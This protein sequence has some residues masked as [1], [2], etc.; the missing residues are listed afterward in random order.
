MGNELLLASARRLREYLDNVY[1][2]YTDY[3]AG[4]VELNELEEV[5]AQVIEVTST[6]LRLVTEL[7]Q[8]IKENGG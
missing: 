7:S 2:E 1:Y 8:S 3:M 4:E 5:R 6:A